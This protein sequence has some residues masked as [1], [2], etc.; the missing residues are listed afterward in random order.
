MIT[1][2]KR[3]KINPLVRKLNDWYDANDNLYISININIDTY[4]ESLRHNRCVELY[5]DIVSMCWK[6]YSTKLLNA[7]S[8][9]EWSVNADDVYS[10]I[11]Y[12]YSR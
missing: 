7:V 1:R 5:N 11:W 9:K 6:K 8:Y 3:K 4:A 2:E 12:D 10:I